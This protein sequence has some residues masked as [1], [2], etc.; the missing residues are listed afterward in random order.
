MSRP[1]T[2][3]AFDLGNISHFLLDGA[4]VYTHCG[5]VIAAAL[6]LLALL[7][8]RNSL[9]VVLVLFRV[10]GGSLLSGKGLCST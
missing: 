1:M 2:V 9:L 5:G 6:S 10:G 8:P 7:A 3:V 4:S